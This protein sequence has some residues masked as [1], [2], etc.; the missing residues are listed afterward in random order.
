MV[1]NENTETDASRSLAAY[2]EL[3]KLS[4][5]N[6]P[7]VA[8]AGA[9]TPAGRVPAAPSTVARIPNAGAGPISDLPLGTAGLPASTS[10]PAQFVSSAHR[11]HVSAVGSL[12]SL[13]A[14]GLAI[15][16]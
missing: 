5:V 4:P 16:L 2:K 12:G 14:I 11:V 9:Q 6:L 15:F 3:A 10:P 8:P 1:I 13:V 7:G